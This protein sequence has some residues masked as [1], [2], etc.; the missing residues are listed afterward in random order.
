MLSRWTGYFHAIA[1][2]HRSRTFWLPCLTFT[3]GQSIHS[4]FNSFYNS[5]AAPYMPQ[6]AQ[7]NI[8]FSSTRSPSLR[9]RRCTCAFLGLRPQLGYPWGTPPVQEGHCGGGATGWFDL[10]YIPNTVHPSMDKVRHFH[11]K[12]DTYLSYVVHS[13][14]GVPFHVA[15]TALLIHVK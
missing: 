5:T 10:E 13:K 9:I 8:L 14:R 7:S 15:C 2:S 3:F 12:S 6:R 4:I 11:E 1:V